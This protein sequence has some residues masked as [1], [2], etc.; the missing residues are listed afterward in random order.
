MAF[1]IVNL[2]ALQAIKNQE[3]VRE[4]A[5]EVTQQL[6]DW[7]KIGSI[8]PWTALKKPWL[9]AGF[10]LVDRPGKDTRICLN[11]SFMKPLELNTFPCTASDILNM[12]G[13]LR[14]AREQRAATFLGLSLL[15]RKPRYASVARMC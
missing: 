11:G 12:L 13:F 15:A 4:R 1:T 3:S 5:D 2:S 14:G 7:A 8:E 6:K 10:I 9:T